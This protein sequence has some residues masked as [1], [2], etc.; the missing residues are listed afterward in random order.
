[1]N[2]LVIFAII[3]ILILSLVLPMACGDLRLLQEMEDISSGLAR[4]DEAKFD[5]DKWD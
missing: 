1:M 4:W 2:K 5:E 3:I